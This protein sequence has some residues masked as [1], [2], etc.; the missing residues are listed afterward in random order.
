MKIF[1]GLLLAIS[2]FPILAKASESHQNHIQTENTGLATFNV[3]NYGA[4]GIKEDNV[5]FAIQ[6]DR[7]PPAAK[8]IRLSFGHDFY[9]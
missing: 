9:S 5:Q 8:K 7:Q 4:S 2:F 6:D 3:R 1:F